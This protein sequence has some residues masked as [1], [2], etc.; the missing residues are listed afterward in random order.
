MNHHARTLEAIVRLVEALRQHPERH[1]FH[2]VGSLA[3]GASQPNDLDLL[4]DCRDQSIAPETLRRYAGLLTMA[5]GR[6]TGI[7]GVFDPFLAF[8]DGLVTRTAS[9]N[10]WRRADN[11]AALLANFTAEKRPFADV[12]IDLQARHDRHRPSPFVAVDEGD[13]KSLPDPADRP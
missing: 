6:F 10:A 4:V 12:R 2:I 13:R 8:R 1:R 3:R 5:Q 7:E 9:A 11:A